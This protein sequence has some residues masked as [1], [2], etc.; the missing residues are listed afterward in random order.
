MG[1]VRINRNRTLCIFT[2]CHLG[3]SALIALGILEQLEIQGLVRPLD[4]M[5]HNS[6]EYLHALIEALRSVDAFF[7]LC[8]PLFSGSSL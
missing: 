7:L 2:I 5:A 6:T 1:K 3:I 8:V 4:E